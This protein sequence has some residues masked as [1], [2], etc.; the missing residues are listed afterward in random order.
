MTL[1]LLDYCELLLRSRLYENIVF[2][3]AI[4]APSCEKQA[5]YH[6]ETSINTQQVV[7]KSDLER[8]KTKMG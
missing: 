1:F 6:H 5:F 3:R 8:F 4:A 7:E 2:V